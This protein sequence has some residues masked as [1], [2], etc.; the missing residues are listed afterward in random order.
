MFALFL[1]LLNIVT[2]IVNKSIADSKT[3]KLENFRCPH[4]ST[5]SLVPTSDPVLQIINKTDE[6]KYLFD[7][8]RNT[9][10]AF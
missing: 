8:C 4:R 1:V 7:K 6:N 2:N 9:W 5:Y 3:A 10:S